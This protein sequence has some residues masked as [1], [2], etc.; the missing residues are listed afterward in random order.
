MPEVVEIHAWLRMV[1]R[2]DDR[3]AAVRILGGSRYRL[4]LGDIRYLSKWAYRRGDGRVRALLDGLEDDRFWHGLPDGLHEPFG[5]F[6]QEYRYILAACQGV[7]AGEA[8]RIILERTRAWADVESIPDNTRLTV[9]LNLYRFLDLA[10]SWLP[11]E[12]P[13]TTEGFLDFLDALLEEPSEEVDAA[14]PVG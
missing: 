3:E 6:R 2:F 13:S 11:L 7:P 5:E 12:G 1:G 9:R 14:R 8:C 4:G 10:E